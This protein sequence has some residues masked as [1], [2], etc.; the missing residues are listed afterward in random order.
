M[1]AAD[2]PSGLAER[3]C[4]DFGDPTWAAPPPA[5]ER[6]V[7][8]VSTAGLIQRGDRPFGLGAADYRVIDTERDADLLMTH[9]STNFDRSAF[10]QDHESVFPVGA[11]NAAAADGAIQARAR[12]HF[13]FMGATRPEQMRPA[14]EQLARAM[15]GEGTNVALL[16]PV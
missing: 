14:V 9:I 2:V 7:A 8:I 12:Y 13:S 5:A 6:R 15:A 10:L 3:P 16:V 11:L 1:R 4:P